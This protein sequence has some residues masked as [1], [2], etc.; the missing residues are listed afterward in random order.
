MG[1]GSRR[2]SPLRWLAALAVLALGALV[3]VAGSLMAVLGAELPAPEEARARWPPRPARPS[4]DPA[5]RGCGSTSRPARRFDVDWTFLASIGYPGVR[6]RPCAEVN[7]SGCGGPMQIA[8]VRE[9]ACSPAR[10]RRSGSATA[11]TPTATAGRPVINLADA[12]FTAARMLRPVFGLRRRLL[13]RLS[14]GRLQLLRRLLRRRRCH[15]ADEVMAR[16]VEYGFEGKA[17]RRRP[18]LP[19][20]SRSPPRAAAVAAQSSSGAGPMGPVRKAHSP[21][22]LAPL[23]PDVATAPGMQ[24][25]ARI[26]P[27]VV[28]LARRFGILVTACYAPTGHEATGEHPL[29]AAIDARAARRQL[30]PDDAPRARALG[31]KPVLRGNP[32]SRPNAPARPSA[33]RLQRLPNHGDPLH[34]VPCAGGPHIHLSWLTSASPAEPET[35]GALRLRTGELDRSLHLA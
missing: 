28:Y 30:E 15:Y 24:C 3:F 1:R 29:G 22:R 14:P 27:D 7:P 2:R 6:H 25:D 4:G 31:W 11:S 20:P 19:A 23:P 21:R 34:C 16:A 8:I 26:V 33:S 32:A 12:I 5:E 9:S 35:P 18:T 13:R 17:A 10:G